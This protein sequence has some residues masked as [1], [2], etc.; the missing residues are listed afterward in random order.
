MPSR[1][2]QDAIRM[3]SGCHDNFHQNSNSIRLSAGWNEGGGG[4]AS[5]RGLINQCL[6]HMAV[7]YLLVCGASPASPASPAQRIARV[8]SNN[9]ESSDSIEMEPPS[10]PPPPPPSPLPHP[11]PLIIIHTSYEFLFAFFSS[12]SLYPPPPSLPP[13]H[14]PS[15]LQ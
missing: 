15:L 8:S 7:A 14:P 12:S 4:G 10:A 6:S 9:A 5:G 11:S 13:F 3:P 2:H 1:C